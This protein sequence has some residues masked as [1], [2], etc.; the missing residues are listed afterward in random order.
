MEIYIQE[1]CPEHMRRSHE[2]RAVIRYMKDITIRHPDMRLMRSFRTLQG[3]DTVMCLRGLDH[4]R[5]WDYSL[6]R[7]DKQLQVIRDHDFLSYLNTSVTRKPHIQDDINRR[8]RNL[9]LVP[10]NYQPTEDDFQFV[11]QALRGARPV[12]GDWLPT[13]TPTPDPNDDTSDNSDSD[14][15]GDGGVSHDGSNPD[16][17]G[18]GAGHGNDDDAGPFE[19]FPHGMP[20]PESGLE[21]PGLAAD[22]DM[23]DDA[24]DEDDDGDGDDDDD[25][26]DDDDGHSGGNGLGGCEHRDVSM[27]SED[28]GEVKAETDIAPGTTLD[29]STGLNSQVTADNDVVITGSRLI[30]SDL[31]RGATP[32]EAILLDE[33]AEE[34]LEEAPEYA[35]S[36]EEE[37]LFVEDDEPREFKSPSP[38]S[39]REPSDELVAAEPQTP[40][41][42][43]PQPEP[44]SDDR[45]GDSYA[46]RDDT[47]SENLF[48]S[49]PLNNPTAGVISPEAASEG[50]YSP[51]IFQTPQRPRNA[52]SSPVGDEPGLFIGDTPANSHSTS[53]EFSSV[54]SY[55]PHIFRSSPLSQQSGNAGG[56]SAGSSRDT[57]MIV[58]DEP[59]ETSPTVS[60]PRLTLQRRPGFTL[61]TSPA[62]DL[63]TR[64]NIGEVMNERTQSSSPGRVST[65]QSDPNVVEQRDLHTRSPYWLDRA[66]MNFGSTSASPSNPAS[67]KRAREDEDDVGMKEADEIPSPKRPRDKDPESPGND[68]DALME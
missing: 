62:A 20:T 36:D 11:I 65:E 22:V 4:A 49:P 52:T 51:G 9:K 19:G 40:L 1:S 34:A 59:N 30:I 45:D 23:G 2:P 54:V 10:A 27:A 56:L 3:L 58:D 24:D 16:D 21:S 7:K 15:S 43:G 46:S 29:P 12:G 26:D 17:D 5:L 57:P 60:T 64:M 38:S 31:T 48:I 67:P 13:P 66:S 42:L 18:D 14:G 63:L 39:P 68:G 28:D 33:P 55:G 37:G 32:Q 44:S 50:R 61:S 35:A 53:P 6:W 8:M 47:N 25:D 41:P